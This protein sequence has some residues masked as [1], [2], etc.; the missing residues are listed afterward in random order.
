MTTLTGEDILARLVAPMHGAQFT[1]DLC[2][3]KCRSLR[4]L[5]QHK[6]R[7]VKAGSTRRAAATRTAGSAKK[8]RAKKPFKA[9]VSRTSPRTSQKSRSA[10]P[11]KLKAT[12]AARVHRAP[13]PE[14]RVAAAEVRAVQARAAKAEARAAKAEARAA[15]AEARADEKR[16]VPAAL[17]A[18]HVALVLRLQHGLQ[19]ELIS[20]L[21]QLVPGA[22]AVEPGQTALVARIAKLEQLLLGGPGISRGIVSRIAA[23]EAAALGSVAPQSGSLFER[24]ALLESTFQ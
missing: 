4:G 12:A 19:S 7:H 20:T 16:V 24:L 17:G 10:A 1:C 8:S 3:H 13:V 9:K 5:T 21:R 15:K 11:K 2:N 6:L 18:D 14:A 23:L 22:P